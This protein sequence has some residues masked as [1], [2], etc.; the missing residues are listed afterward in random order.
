MS[1]NTL[2]FVN[3]LIIDSQSLP[4]SIR[5]NFALQ[6]ILYNI[7]KTLMMSELEVIYLSLFLDKMGW[8]TEGYQLDENLLITG[9]SVKMYLNTNYMFFFEHLSKTMKIEDQFNT[10]LSKKKDFSH[11]MNISPRE[12]NERY[13]SFSR[14]VNKYCKNNYIDYNSIVDQILQMSM[15]YSEGKSADR[16]DKY[17]RFVNDGS[18][19]D[20][21]HSQVHDTSNVQLATHNNLKETF[22]FKGADMKYNARNINNNGNIFNLGGN[23]AVNNDEANNYPMNQISTVNV[24]N[25]SLNTSVDANRGKNIN[26][27]NAELSAGS[28]GNVASNISNIAG[29]DIRSASS[30]VGTRKVIT[31]P[32]EG[33]NTPPSNYLNKNEKSNSFISYTNDFYNHDPRYLMNMPSNNK[34]D[35]LAKEPS[36]FNDGTFSRYPSNLQPNN[37]DI[38]SIF[39]P[40]KAFS[41]QS[42]SNK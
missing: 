26:S 6:K 10:W 23:I 39:G 25:A 3:R 32:G 34:I 20:H 37:E 30:I 40:Y 15:P 7:V 16:G 8:Q 24:A 14:P 17:D 42:M 22:K 19:V 1:S 2:I 29:N 18:S 31:G 11:S 38:S 9:V 28:I 12:L 5:T 33:D 4:S 13:K 35:L 21:S 41:N 36:F 27:L